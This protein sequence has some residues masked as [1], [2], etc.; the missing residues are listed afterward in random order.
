MS[1]C[2]RCGQDLATVTTHGLHGQNACMEHL[3]TRLV[4]ERRQREAA[5]AGATRLDGL[6]AE[7]E[8]HAAV[9][10]KLRSGRAA[11][12]LCLRHI[13]KIAASRHEPVKEKPNVTD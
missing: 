2:N 10:E 13:V 7:A 1:E 3:R 12:M 11:A 4:T 5:E 8:E 6:L 9:P